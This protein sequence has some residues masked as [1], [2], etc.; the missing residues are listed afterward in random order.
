MKIENVPETV[1]VEKGVIT[2]EYYFMISPLAPTCKIFS[3]QTE[4]VPVTSSTG[5][6]YAMII[7]DYDSYNIL[8]GQEQKI[9]YYKGS[10]ND[11]RN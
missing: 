4:C 6:K 11:I 5:N 9:K 10:R 7:Y 1:E 2:G 3:D 8:G